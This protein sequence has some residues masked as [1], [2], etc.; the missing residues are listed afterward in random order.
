MTQKQI[1]LVSPAYI[2]N[3]YDTATGKFTAAIPTHIR[4]PIRSGEGGAKLLKNAAPSK[5]AILELTA[6]GK[7]VGFGKPE[8][9][10]KTQRKQF[11]FMFVGT[12]QVVT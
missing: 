1:V 11:L 9:R 6:L 7:K 5:T 10:N 12:M 2:I 8:T 3:E 4:N